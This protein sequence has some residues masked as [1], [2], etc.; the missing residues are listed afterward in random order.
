MMNVKMLKDLVE[1]AILKGHDMESMW[2]E[3]IATCDELDIEIDL[4]DRVMISLAERI[5]RTVKGEVVC[6]AN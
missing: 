5:Y 3:I 4:M 1:I 2:L 6:K